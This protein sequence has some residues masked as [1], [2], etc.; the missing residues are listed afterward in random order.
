M[1]AGGLTPKIYVPAPLGNE[2]ENTRVKRQINSFLVALSTRTHIEELRI[3]NVNEAQHME[4]LFLAIS[5]KLSRDANLPFLG[6]GNS[7]QVQAGKC[8]GRGDP[9]KRCHVGVQMGSVEKTQG[10]DERQNKRGALGLRS[11]ATEDP[12]RL[13]VL[14]VEE[15]GDEHGKAKRLYAAPT[16]VACG[17]DCEG[18]QPCGR[19]STRDGWWTGP[20][21]FMMLS[22]LAGNGCICR[23]HFF[24]G[25]I[26]LIGFFFFLVSY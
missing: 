19:E 12:C 14:A 24:G 4:P 7:A 17:S 20:I 3:V 1:S 10:Y 13:L 9:H 25:G 15:E 23:F 22:Q 26:G 16:V 6:G 21:S 11:T 18:Y 5:S 8:Q 2:D